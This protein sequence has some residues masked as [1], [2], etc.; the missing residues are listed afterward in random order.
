MDKVHIKHNLVYAKH[1]GCLMGFVNLGEIN[2]KLI[3]F[4]QALSDDQES[5]QPTLASSMIVLMVQGLLC[6]LNFQYAQ[7]A[8]NDFSGGLLFDPVWM[9]VARLEKVW[10]F[11]LGLTCHGTSTNCQFWKLHSE[12]DDLPYKVLNLY[13][14]DGRYL[15]LI[16]HISLKQLGTVFFNNKNK[17]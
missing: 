6:K 2:N 7:F 9:A 1:E 14:N 16:H 15:Y 12:N 13:A 5:A 8:C 3:K 17:L 4:G 11:V 10:F